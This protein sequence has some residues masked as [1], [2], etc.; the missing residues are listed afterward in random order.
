MRDDG[1][2]N[3]WFAEIK[4]NSSLELLLQKAA[5]RRRKRLVR[6]GAMGAFAMACVGLICWQIWSGGQP[7]GDLG[8]ASG[9]L[10]PLPLKALPPAPRSFEGT[11]SANQQNQA[12][13]GTNVDSAVL[14]PRRNNDGEG[15][16]SQVSI[17]VIG[18][19]ELFE[20]LEGRS[21]AIVG[22]KGS[23]RVIFLDPT[24]ERNRLAKKRRE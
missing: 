1:L 13:V 3:D 23:R 14:N 17:K 24:T 22:E 2:W 16:V 20:L 12:S 6:Y 21:F 19:E 10:K 15:S 18:D 11:D 5:K 7:F 4:G 8:L 9:K